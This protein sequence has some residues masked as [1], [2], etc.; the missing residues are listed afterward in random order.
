MNCQR[1]S[2][3]L[4][5]LLFFL[6]GCQGGDD[7]T[8]YQ[9]PRPKDREVERLL[10]AILSQQDGESWFFKFTGPS[11]LVTEHQKDFSAF[12]QTVRLDD[13]ADAVPTW[14]LPDGWKEE[15]AQG[16]RFATLRFGPEQ[17]L[18]ITVGRAGGSVLA[19]VNRWLGQIGLGSAATETELRD[20]KL[21]QEVTIHDRKVFLVDLTGPGASR[22]RRGMA[23][24]APA[25]P[26]A[27]GEQ[28]EEIKFDLP[29]GW[30]K[31][32][33]PSSVIRLAF[34]LPD[35]Q[36]KNPEVTIT[37]LGGDGGG[38]L[39]NYQRWQKQ[40]GLKESSELPRNQKTI[41]VAGA[42]ATFVDL[43][44]PEGKDQQRTLVVVC[45]HGNGTWYFKMQ[46]RADVVAKQ[47]SAFE[48]FV[49]SVRF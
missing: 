26:A 12:M 33:P 47:Q 42:E 44:G 24:R 37:A 19:N 41:Q 18:E 17:S 34:R 5:T 16:L 23:A 29:A 28:P 3:L 13:N 45:K 15:K 48:A 27:Q 1:F 46:A 10:G 43:Q 32:P 40:I 31:V 11:S 30:K 6:A 14:K 2:F 8:H 22:S 49:K 25:R 20:Q 21:V 4:L 36:E 38:L 7:I 35:S 9:V 39:A